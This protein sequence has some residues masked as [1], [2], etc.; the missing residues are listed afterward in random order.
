MYNIDIFT[1]ASSASRPLQDNINT[2]EEL[3]KDTG[4]W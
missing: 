1:L 3:T 4:T 2:N